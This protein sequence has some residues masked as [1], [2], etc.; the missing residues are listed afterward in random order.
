[1]LIPIWRCSWSSAGAAP[2]TSE[3]S[4]TLLPNKVPPILDVLRYVP[5]N[6]CVL[7]IIASLIA[8]YCLCRLCLIGNYFSCNIAVCKSIHNKKYMFLLPCQWTV[9][10]WAFIFHRIRVLEQCFCLQ[11]INPVQV[12][13]TAFTYVTTV[14]NQKGLGSYFHEFNDQ[15]TLQQCTICVHLFLY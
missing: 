5:Q 12:S 2:T 1:M 14:S 11:P 9:L 10:I 15:F 7:W 3:W 8:I 13:F 6:R 4:T